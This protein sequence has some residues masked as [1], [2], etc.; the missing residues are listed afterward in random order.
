MKII[1][2]NTLQQGDVLL[3]HGNHHLSKIIRFLDQSNY[4]HCA[5]YDKDNYVYEAV[6][7][8][9]V[10][11]TLEESVKDSQATKVNVLRLNTAPRDMEKVLD[12]IKCFSKTTKYSVSQLLL[13][14]FFLLMQKMFSNTLLCFL[15][16]VFGVVCM[17]VLERLF[18]KKDKGFMCSE[19]VYR[20]FNECGCGV[21][22]IE[23]NTTKGILSC[24]CGE[25]VFLKV[26]ASGMKKCVK[27]FLEYINKKRVGF[28][29]RIRTH[30]FITPGDIERSLS[31]NTVGVFFC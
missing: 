17:D 29:A 26:K 15:W 20:C 9:V 14:A 23:L 18:D 7:G 19:L 31:L 22:S 25:D 21:Y 24:L 5:I 10:R 16:G 6:Y 3:Y 4:N 28:K 30:N 11:R 27:R 2:P 12:K 1:T 13:L 8:G